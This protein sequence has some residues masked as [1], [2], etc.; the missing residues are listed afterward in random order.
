MNSVHNG[1]FTQ[2]WEVISHT[3]NVREQ[4]TLAMTMRMIWLRRNK[5][6]H[7]GILQHPTQVAYYGIH[8]AE[9]IALAQSEGPTMLESTGLNNST[10]NA[11]LWKGPPDLVVKANWDA[12]LHSPTNSTGIGVIYRDSSGDVLACSSLVWQTKL[13]PSLAEAMG[14]LHAIKLA[15]ELGFNNLLVEGDSSI[16]VDAIRG[17]EI[18]NVAA[19]NLAKYSFQEQGMQVWIE[20]VPLAIKEVIQDEKREWI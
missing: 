7:E 13:D 18:I 4:A 6:V 20:E 19:H 2:F 17:E 1:S 3:L 9:D 8:S 5:F 16:I 10:L 15:R 11:Q 14:A 12:A